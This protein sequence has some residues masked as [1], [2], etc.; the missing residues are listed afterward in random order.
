MQRQMGAVAFADSDAEGTDPCGYVPNGQEDRR[1]FEYGAMNPRCGGSEGD[2]RSAR[3]LVAA[4][5]VRALD[6]LALGSKLGV[7]ARRWIDAH[8]PTC[9]WSFDWCCMVLK[10][11][12]DAV[13]ERLGDHQLRCG[14]RRN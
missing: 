8:E 7:S 10:L 3:A 5:L 12:P 9:A 2:P 13:R 6:D 11:D 14:Y 1:H 4:V